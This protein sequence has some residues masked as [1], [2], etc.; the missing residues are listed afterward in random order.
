MAEIRH[1]FY[2]AILF[3]AAWSLAAITPFRAGRWIG[4]V[5]VFLGYPLASKGRAVVSRNLGHVTGMRGAKLE[6]LCRK[7]IFNFGRMLADYFCASRAKPEKILSLFAGRHGLDKI[8]SA[9]ERGKGVILVTAHLGNWELGAIHLASMGETV[10]VVTREEPSLELTRWR[11]AYRS[12]LGIK[13]IVIGPD[14]FA[15]VE[16]MHALRRNEL[17]ALLADRPGADTGVSVRFFDR[18]TEFSVAPALLW[19]QTGASVVPVFVFQNESD[20]YIAHAGAAIEMID[21]DERNETLM[22]NTQRIATA[23]EAI[24]REHPDQWFNYSTIWKTD[25][26]K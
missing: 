25:D 6:A 16:I 5:V 11:E 7:N 2:S 12:R 8:T 18:E 22:Q 3:K 4:D 15:F 24:I 17:V 21:Y 19:K 26:G 14:K 1:P 23:F 9:R 20:K 10:T 13:T